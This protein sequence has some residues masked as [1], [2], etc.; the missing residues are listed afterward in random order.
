MNQHPSYLKI[1]EDRGDRSSSSSS[2]SGRVEPFQTQSFQPINQAPPVWAN[3]ERLPP[4]PIQTTSSFDR[5]TNTNS[6]LP[7]RNLFDQRG[8][9]EV[10]PHPADN[11]AFEGFPHDQHNIDRPGVE[12]EDTKQ[13]L[14]G[15]SPS[16]FSG[17]FHAVSSFHQIPHQ[18]YEDHHHP[19]FEPSHNPFV[20]HH[21]MVYR[22]EPQYLPST[23]HAMYKPTEM[24][25]KP[26][27][28]YSPNRPAISPVKH[29]GA[30]PFFAHSPPA[31]SAPLPPI[32]ANVPPVASRDPESYTALH[33]PSTRA[34]AVDGSPPS[35]ALSS[36]ARTA[37]RSKKARGGRRESMQPERQHAHESPST[38]ELEDAP[39]NR[40]RKAIHSWYTRYN[41]LVDYANKFGDST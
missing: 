25:R 3:T 20:S 34:A 29:P 32:G 36:R 10:L 38:K 6:P 15:P 21:H 40:A 35:P 14:A 12:R 18:S 33:N 19:P 26:A 1:F 28:S 23:W 7:L 8:G 31:A 5:Y 16:A 24:D 9:G 41:E 4:S 13:L 22:F 30:P 39:T 27:P 11:F 17:G 37:R 2:G